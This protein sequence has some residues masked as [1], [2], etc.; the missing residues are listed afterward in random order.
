MRDN[1][2]Q[3]TTPTAGGSVG[4]HN[5]VPLAGEESKTNNDDASAHGPEDHDS[6]TGRDEAGPCFADSNPPSRE[7]RSNGLR[8]ALSRVGDNHSN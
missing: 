3:A 5:Q 4:P 8:R 1:Q 7:L 2:D 6:A